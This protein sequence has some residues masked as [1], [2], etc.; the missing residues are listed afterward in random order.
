[1]TSHEIVSRLNDFDIDVG[2]TYID[3]EPLGNIHIVPLY[4]ER[5]LFLTPD[6]GP[7]SK[8]E[9]ISWAEAASAQLCLLTPDMQNRRILD[10]YFVEA[11]VEARPVVETDTISAI[12]AHIASM[13]LSSVI[14]HTWLHD[15]K[16]P[17]GTRALRLP[18]PNRDYHV[19]LVL[20]SREPGSMLARALVETAREVDVHAH[21]AQAMARLGRST[22]ID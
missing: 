5:Y 6:D 10:G 12:Y 17:D 3:G 14:P 8:K 15:L 16:V 2:M 7:F 22:P 13:R 21:L 4:R 18:R 11:G 9:S 20:A 19:G 1:M